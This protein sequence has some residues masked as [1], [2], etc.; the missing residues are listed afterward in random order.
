M[1]IDVIYLHNWMSHTD[2]KVDFRDTKLCVLL[3]DNGS[4][5]SSVLE[6]ITYALFGV[7]RTTDSRGAG[8]DRVITDGQDV[9]WVRVNWTM[10]G[11]KYSVQRKRVREN[12]TFL[13][14]EIN[15]AAFEGKIAEVQDMIYQLIGIDV[16]I[17]NITMNALQERV[18]ILSSKSTD[19]KK[20]LI[21]LLDLEK[22]E[23]YEKRV[24]EEYSTEKRV[25]LTHERTYSDLLAQQEQLSRVDLLEQQAILQD[26]STL[27]SSEIRQLEQLSEESRDK[28]DLIKQLETKLAELN[29]QVRQ[30]QVELSREESSLTAIV[31]NLQSLQSVQSELD[32]RVE[33]EQT[34]RKIKELTPQVELDELELE[35]LKKTTTEQHAAVVKLETTL[36]QLLSKRAKLQENQ[37]KSECDW[38]GNILNSE[39]HLSLLQQVTQ[40]EN[41]KNE[42]RKSQMEVLRKLS[43]QVEASKKKLKNSS[44]SLNKNQNLLDKLQ[45]SLDNYLRVTLPQMEY[46]N[47]QKDKTELIVQEKKQDKQQLEEKRQKQQQLVEQAK[48]ELTVNSDVQLQQLIR[49]K[50]QVEEDLYQNKKAQDELA[51][52]DSKIKQ[53]AKQL[54]VSSERIRILD[55]LK[56]SVGKNGIPLKIV[57]NTLPLLESRSSEVLEKLGSDLR[58]EFSTVKEN[59]DGKLSD[60]LDIWV[61][62]SQNKRKLVE[63]HSGGEK[64][65][66]DL[67]LRIACCE[68]LGATKNSEQLQT[69]LLDEYFGPLD[70]SGQ[71]KIMSILDHIAHALDLRVLF[72]THSK[73]VQEYA[74]SRYMFEKRLGVSSVIKY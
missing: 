40:E 29:Q 57:E 21:N 36:D 6:A 30:I 3:G 18:S 20:L 62:D 65:R 9:M 35:E 45:D 19:R 51:E 56:R 68:L 42:Q 50:K 5:K 16:N 71:D 28:K 60:T 58:L 11:N 25:Y 72:V 48:Q 64:L 14:L 67:S 66:L 37:D 24:A 1:K 32:R 70:E 34:E 54:K 49:D 8:I 39:S 15:G 47:N 53:Q 23:D 31:K 7:A 52:V 61:L 44:E 41:E 63:L 69:L 43:V 73:Q 13:D 10:Q 59:K 33:I 27:I 38:C 55:K 26:K 22:F 2:T 46:L 74:S 4:G 12:M 17:W